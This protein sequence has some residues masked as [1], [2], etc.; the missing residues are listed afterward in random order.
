ME[1]IAV[2]SVAQLYPSGDT[3]G[4]GEAHMFAFTEYLASL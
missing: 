3:E 4:C 2:A 1:E